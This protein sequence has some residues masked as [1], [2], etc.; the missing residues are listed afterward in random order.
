M[1]TPLRG[2]RLPADPQDR[3]A[4]QGAGAGGGGR[5]AGR[6]GGTLGRRPRDHPPRLRA[7]GAGAAPPRARGGGGDSAVA[8]PLAAAGPLPAGF[9]D[10][11]LREPG[12]GSGLVVVLSGKYAV[13]A[14]VD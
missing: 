5:V 7:Q 1:L 6:E 13:Q 9:P 8:E 2:D 4:V 3:H 14:F 10:Q 11:P 12:H